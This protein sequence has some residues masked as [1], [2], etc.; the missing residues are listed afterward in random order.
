MSEIREMIGIFPYGI[1][2]LIHDQFNDDYLSTHI[3]LVTECVDALCLAE[4]Y[5]GR[6]RACI[7]TGQHKLELTRNIDHLSKRCSACYW[8]HLV[9]AWKMERDFANSWNAKE[10]SQ[11]IGQL[12]GSICET[13]GVRN[14]EH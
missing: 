1:P 7:V 6:I 5:Y 9:D 8:V 10:V 14:Y 13:A 3:G 4:I 11:R 12:L 2:V